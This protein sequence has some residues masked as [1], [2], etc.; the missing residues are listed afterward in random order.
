MRRSAWWCFSTIGTY[1]AQNLFRICSVVLTYHRNASARTRSV[2]SLRKLPTMRQRSKLYNI[3]SQ[4]SAKHWSPRAGRGAACCS[5]LH[6]IR[7]TC[8]GLCRPTVGDGMPWREEDWGGTDSDLSNDSGVSTLVGRSR[9]FAGRG[10]V[11]VDPNK[12]SL[13]KTLATSQ[14]SRSIRSI[15]PIV[16]YPYTW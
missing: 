9:T 15:I 5:L 7:P 10:E 12:S 3:L 1:V 14:C 8:A 2:S 4:N 6:G 11:D 16:T 13:K